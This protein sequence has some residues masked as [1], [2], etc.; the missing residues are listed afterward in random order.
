MATGQVSFHDQKLTKKILVPVRQNAII[1]RLNKT[2][3][4]QFPDLY[5]EREED[6]KEKRKVER[7]AREE[8]KRAEKKELEEREAKRYQKDHAYDDIM[9]EDDIAANS[10]QDREGVDPEDDFF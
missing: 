10:N 8:R 1:N 3:V 5:A 7:I 9:N 2:K 4:E 6:L